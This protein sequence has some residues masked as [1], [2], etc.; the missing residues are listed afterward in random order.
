[1]IRV[2]VIVVVIFLV[3]AGFAWLA[4][5]PGGL[6]LM[7]QGY[8]IR[9]SLMVAAIGIAATIAAIEPSRSPIT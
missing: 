1:M 4:E 7:W 2:L 6:V 5:R 9:T 3:A 8:E